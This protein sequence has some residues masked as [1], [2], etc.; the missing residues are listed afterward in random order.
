MPEGNPL[1]NPHNHPENPQKKDRVMLVPVEQLIPGIKPPIGKGLENINYRSNDLQD[2]FVNPFLNTQIKN[3]TWD[4]GAYEVLG[5][6]FKDQILVDLGAGRSQ[7]YLIGVLLGCKGYVGVEKF[8]SKQ[9]T[10]S[11]RKTSLKSVEANFEKAE[12]FLE[13]LF[14][15]EKPEMHLVPASI[16][17]EDMLSFLQ[18][19]PDSSVSILASGIDEHVIPDNNYRAEISKELERVLSRNGMCITYES[20]I[21]TGGLK[22]FDSTFKKD[23][24]SGSAGFA[25]LKSNLFVKK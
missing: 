24:A 1:E 23:G 12:F 13:E 6:R 20:D 25:M 5:E 16:V 2:D 7:G 4:K 10:E 19:L 18:R 21:S 17:S 8:F 3:L 14:Q 22:S 11:V 9:L 15:A